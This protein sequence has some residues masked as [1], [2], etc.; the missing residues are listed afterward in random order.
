M[1]LRLPVRLGEFLDPTFGRC[2]PVFEHVDGCV[3]LVESGAH[4]GQVGVALLHDRGVA[5][6]YRGNSI[7]IA[8]FFFGVG[9][10]AF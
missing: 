2:Q 3:S 8:V 4:A 7:G 6:S 1:W 9:N 5:I 10:L